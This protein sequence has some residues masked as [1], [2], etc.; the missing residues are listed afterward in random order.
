MG[1]IWKDIKHEEVKRLVSFHNRYIVSNSVDN[2][3]SEKRLLAKGEYLDKRYLD[4]IEN[5]G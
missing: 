3:D 4:Y 5:H 2:N 1:N